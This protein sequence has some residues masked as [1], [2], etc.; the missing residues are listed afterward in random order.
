MQNPKLYGLQRLNQAIVVKVGVDR[1]GSNIS[2]AQGVLGQNKI[3]GPLVE[4][5][6]KGMPQGM[7]S[8]VL[9]DPACL[10]PLLE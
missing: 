2:M 8:K 10:E 7:D 3:V 6:G 5:T 1:G 4:V 9:L